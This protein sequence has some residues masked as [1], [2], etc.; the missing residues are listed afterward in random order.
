MKQLCRKKQPEQVKFLLLEAAGAIAA[1]EGVDAVTLER[2]ARDAGVSKGGLLHHFPSR[3]ALIE[4]LVEE[5][6][7]R[8]DREI[9]RHMDADPVAEGRFTRAYVMS[10]A[11]VGDS[12]FDIRVIGALTMAMSVDDNLRKH[13]T[14]WLANHTA[15][16]DGKEWTIERRMVR[17][18]ADGLWLADYTGT[19]IP[20]RGEMV[21]QL[22]TMAREWRIEP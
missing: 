2:V 6:F 14:A 10:T 5:M 18:A 4:A 8:W 21:R 12:Q 19:A 15:R 11:T 13:W 9:A 1:A 7:A 3:R 17:A 20:D 16:E 22:I